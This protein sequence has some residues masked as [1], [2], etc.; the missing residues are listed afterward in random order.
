MK[1]AGVILAAGQGTRMK[2]TLSKVLHPL[3]GRPFITYAIAAVEEVMPGGAVPVLVVGHGQDQ[4]RT[5][6]GDRVAYALQ[7]PQLGT[8]HALLQAEDAVNAQSADVV[9]VTYGDMPLVEAPALRALVDTFARTGGPLVMAATV[10]DDPRGFGRVLRD[11]GG[12]VQAIVEEAQATPE[13]KRIRE[14]NVGIY[15]IDAAWLWPRLRRLPLSP[16][17]EYYL[18]DLVGLATAEGTPV[19]AVTLDDPEQF[20]GINTRV[21]LA[22]AEVVLR[23]RI[24]RR[25]MEA[26]V[27]LLDPAATYIEPGV[28]IG[29]DTVVLPG[30]LLR[31]ATRIG[32]RCI[33]GPHTLVQDTTVGD[34]CRI[35]YS[36][37][38]K[39][40]VADEVSIGPFGHLRSGARLER[41]VHMGNFGEVKNSTLG[42]GVK[43]GHFSYLG[44]AVVGANANIGAGTIT[45]NFDGV[46]KH[47]TVIG[48][49]AFIGSD[50]M[51]VAPVTIGA[52][53]KTGAGSVVT[54][55]VPD[56]AVAYGVPARVKD[57][58]VRT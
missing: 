53:A 4:V 31:G 46:H 1:L 47:K 37:L 24:N 3:G 51:L 32:A 7:E 27:T 33:I 12:A 23:R 35:Q 34:D 29:P 40:V 43:M 54:H 10:V 58:D 52:G 22:E 9:L 16:K 41:G 26:G 56:G 45:C 38:E 25:H 8:G 30:T 13:Q 6:L 57:E 39:A 5:A 17:G 19:H 2:S 21:H 15:V 42:P 49:N 50:S 28:V 48:E 55:D 11:A 20:I 14:L 36:V 44:D 18:T